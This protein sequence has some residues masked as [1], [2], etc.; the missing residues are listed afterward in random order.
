MNV[1]YTLARSLI[2]AQGM[3]FIPLTFQIINLLTHF[4]ILIQICKEI[5]RDLIR[6]EAALLL[7]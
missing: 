3:R 5:S 6:W 4:V 2:L 7:A 1:H